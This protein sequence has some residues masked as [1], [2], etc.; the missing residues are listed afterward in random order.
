[1]LTIGELK[2]A[3][4]ASPARS[5]WS[6]AVKRYAYELVEEMDD[7]KEFYGSPADR[8]ELL[9]GATDWSQYSWG[10]CSLVYDAQIAKRLCTPSELKR[11][12]NGDYRPNIDEEWLDAQAR[13]LYQAE[14]LIFDLAERGGPAC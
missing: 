10:G 4:D 5:K 1:M 6:K 14:Q 2:Q 9:N 3:I 7:S 12:H 11:R 13:A 8:K